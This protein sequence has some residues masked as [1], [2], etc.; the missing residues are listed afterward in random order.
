M[1]YG[2]PKSSIKWDDLQ[3]C[4]TFGAMNFKKV[5]DQRGQRNQ[6]YSPVSNEGCV[7]SKISLSTY[8]MGLA[9]GK[10]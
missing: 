6:L 7:M 5:K 1:A 2:S 8:T 9:H 3:S 10:K 4:K